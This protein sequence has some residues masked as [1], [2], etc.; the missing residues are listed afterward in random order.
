[1]IEMSTPNILIM[2]TSKILIHFLLP[3]N[4]CTVSSFRNISGQ[5]NNKNN[6]ILQILAFYFL[7][8]YS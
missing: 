8:T 6:N 7:F 2:S 4:L 1:M 5:K 3:V